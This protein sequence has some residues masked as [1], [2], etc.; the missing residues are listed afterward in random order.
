MRPPAAFRRPP[1]PP[2]PPESVDPADAASWR[3]VSAA[4]DDAL[5]RL[6]DRYRLP[7]VLCYLHGLTRDEAAARLGWSPDAVRGRLDRGRAKL[8]TLLARRGMGLPAG[9]LAVLLTPLPADAV[10]SRTTAGLASSS[11]GPPAAV[12]ALSTGASTVRTKLLPLIAAPLL[13]VGGVGAMV[14]ARLPGHLPDPP[15]AGPKLAAD[16]AA[17]PPSPAFSGRWQSVL[18]YPDGSGRR[19]Y[20]LDVLDGEHLSRRA[21]IVSPGVDTSA[22]S[23]EAYTLTGDRL[24]LALLNKGPAKGRSRSAPATRA[25]GR[26]RWPGSQPTATRGWS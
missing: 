18:D 15:A 7:L 25:S 5:S 10:W 22:T 8:R 12:V 23:R 17:G 2:A 26:T 6:P 1:V 20:F 4:I 16:P 13:A 14:A 9:L 24:T 11:A 19:T 3:E 21:H